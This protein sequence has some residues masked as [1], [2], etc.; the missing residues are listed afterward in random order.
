MSRTV[1]LHD[2]YVTFIDEFCFVCT[3]RIWFHLDFPVLYYDQITT[4][5]IWV[6][7]FFGKSI[8]EY[9]KIYDRSY[10]LITWRSTWGSKSRPIQDDGWCP[11]TITSEARG[12]LRSRHETHWRIWRVFGQWCW[13][14]GFEYAKPTIENNA[15]INSK[16]RAKVGIWF[17]IV[18]NLKKPPLYWG[19]IDW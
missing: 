17:D 1:M 19:H 9:T 15:L 11:S 4:H 8:N 13:A 6:R 10:V 2:C 18:T 5:V 12:K 16:P 7:G 14:N 3:A